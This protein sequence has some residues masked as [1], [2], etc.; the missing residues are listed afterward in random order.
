M[1]TTTAQKNHISGSLFT[2]LCWS[3][4]FCFFALNFVNK[5]TIKCFS[6]KLNRKYRESFCCY[7]LVV[8]T[9]LKKVF[10]GCNFSDNSVQVL[11]SMH[12]NMQLLYLLL[13]LPSSSASPSS[14]LKVLTTDTRDFALHTQPWK[15]WH[16]SKYISR[17]GRKGK[18][19]LLH[20]SFKFKVIEMQFSPKTLILITRDKRQLQARKA[21][22]P[23]NSLSIEFFSHVDR[24][25]ND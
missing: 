22:I 21:H 11:S 23:T 3:L 12:S 24:T 19:S 17:E 16:G 18:K 4:E 9:T 1:W 2:S 5:K 6:M 10:P 15:L 7:V 14:L 8:P 25:I 20:I 13:F